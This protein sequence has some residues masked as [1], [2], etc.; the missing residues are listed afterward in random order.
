MI[1]IG[2]KPI[3]LEQNVFKIYRRAMEDKYEPLE[4][5]LKKLKVLALI[6]GLI[7]VGIL[8]YKVI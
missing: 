1:I 2:Q 3:Q 6:E 5:K 8:L 7:I 4:L